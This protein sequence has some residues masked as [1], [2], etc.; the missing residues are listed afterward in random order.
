M[1]SRGI[2][3]LGYAPAAVS[4]G[5]LCSKWRQKKRR[6][7]ALCVEGTALQRGKSV[8]MG[9]CGY[10]LTA[11]MASS[12]PRVCCSPVVMFLS[13]MTPSRISFSPT[14]ATKGICRALA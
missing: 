3:L 14:R 13:A 5:F 12:M 10:A 8:W 9:Q 6:T 2:P 7:L 4:P 11:A 1:P